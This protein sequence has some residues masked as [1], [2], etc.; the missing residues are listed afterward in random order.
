MYK[1]V[2][3]NVLNEKISFLGSEKFLLATDN[4]R[5]YNLPMIYYISGIDFFDAKLSNQRMVERD[6]YLKMHLFENG[7]VFQLVYE[8]GSKTLATDYIVID[9]AD[10][11]YVEGISNSPGFYRTDSYNAKLLSSGNFGLLGMIAGD[12][13]NSRKSKKAEEAIGEKLTIVFKDGNGIELFVPSMYWDHPVS[14]YL[15]QYYHKYKVFRF[16][17]N[18]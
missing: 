1:K 16:S 4:D 5:N 11:D 13:F 14:T 6:S 10:V 18:P 7:F 2:S 15:I 17:K 9:I 3:P 8:E 12:L